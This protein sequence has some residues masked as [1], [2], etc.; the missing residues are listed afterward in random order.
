MLAPRVRKPEQTNRE[1]RENAHKRVRYALEKGQLAAGQSAAD[2]QAALVRWARK[3]WPMKLTDLPSSFATNLQAD[4]LRLEDSAVIDVVPGDIASC[5]AALNAA[6]SHN[7]TLEIELRQA[8]AEIE[9]LR[10]MAAKYAAMQKK[11]AQAAR[12]PRT[13]RLRA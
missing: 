7:R 9:R 5:Q 1:A 11:N 12:E 6:Q 8:K 2:P 13:L 3:K 10:P 4:V